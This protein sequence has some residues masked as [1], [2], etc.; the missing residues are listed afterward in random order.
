MALPLWLPVSLRKVQP[1]NFTPRTFHMETWF[2]KVTSLA[3]LM[4][5]VWSAMTILPLSRS[6]GTGVGLS[7]QL[8]LIMAKPQKSIMHKKIFFMII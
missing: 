2:S 6:V 7:L 8:V 5:M 4:F 3:V 1:L